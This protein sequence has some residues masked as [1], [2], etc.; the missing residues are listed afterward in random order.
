M[1]SDSQGGKGVENICAGC[2]NRE[3]CCVYNGQS[4]LLVHERINAIKGVHDE[5][6]R[7]R[8]R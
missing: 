3:L 4:C 2:D 8:R 1:A 7:H 6:K 5:R